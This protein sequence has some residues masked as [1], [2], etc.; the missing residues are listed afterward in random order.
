MLGGG[1]VA[2]RLEGW[3]RRPE[4]WAEEALEEVKVEV[5]VSVYSEALRVE[6]SL[7]V[8]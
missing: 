1:E 5:S 6:G 2:E 7:K 8:R 4:E 3:K